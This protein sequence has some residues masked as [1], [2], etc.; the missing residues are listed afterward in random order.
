MNV[1]AAVLTSQDWGGINLLRECSLS[2]TQHSEAV[3]S[4]TETN[5]AHFLIGSTALGTTP[6]PQS[7]LSPNLGSKK[8]KTT[9]LCS[10][11][12]L[13]HWPLPK[14]RGK[15]T[16][17]SIRYAGAHPLSSTYRRGRG[18]LPKVQS[19]PGLHS[20][21]LSHSKT[22]SRSRGGEGVGENLLL[23]ALMRDVSL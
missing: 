11:V 16:R 7:A 2:G 12:W 4:S 20:R 15:Q 23:L 21:T 6:T 10:L 22:K 13:S 19:Q 3:H 5:S 14:D 1:K 18:E 8:G 9:M 17:A